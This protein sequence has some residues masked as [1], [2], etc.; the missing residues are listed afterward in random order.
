MEIY[1]YFI[2]H[3]RLLVVYAE[4]ISL[5]RK[6]I[7]AESAIDLNVHVNYSKESLFPIYFIFS[8]FVFFFLLVRGKSGFG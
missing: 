1:C 8:S 7:V 3:S 5:H 6:R 4:L 2:F